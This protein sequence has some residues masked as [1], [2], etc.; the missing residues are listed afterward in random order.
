MSLRRHREAYRQEI[1]TRFSTAICST[2]K[3]TKVKICAPPRAAQCVS[4]HREGQ[5]A[6]FSPLTGGGTV[7]FTAG[8]RR[9][10]QALLRECQAS[11][12]ES[13]SQTPPWRWSH[14]ENKNMPRPLVDQPDEAD[15]SA[16]WMGFLIYCASGNIELTPRLD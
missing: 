2:R 8:Q 16:K 9:R 11:G 5:R 13:R 10:S 3:Q 12:Y 15:K 6:V 1:I 7:T 14:L 4:L